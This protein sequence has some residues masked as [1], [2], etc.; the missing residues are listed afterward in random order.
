MS[1]TRRGSET[2]VAA[3]LLRF[4][5]TLGTGGPLAGRNRPPFDQLAALDARDSRIHDFKPPDPAKDPL[6]YKRRAWRSREED[7]RPKNIFGQG[8]ARFCRVGEG[9]VRNCFGKLNDPGKPAFRRLGILPQQLRTSPLFVSGGRVALFPFSLFP[10]NRKPTPT[11]RSPWCI[12][13]TSQVL[14]ILVSSE[15][16][17]ISIAWLHGLQYAA[18]R[19]V[20]ARS[21][22]AGMSS[23]SFR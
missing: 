7:G 6:H 17:A 10:G 11:P 9:D 2:G 21:R 13:V 5:E 19:G 23:I 16:Q 12:Y 20:R 22:D 4:I 8:R 18:G 1:G 15:E 3:A 14:E